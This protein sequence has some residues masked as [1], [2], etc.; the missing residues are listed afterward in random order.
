MRP[1]RIIIVPFEMTSPGLTT[2][3]PPTKACTPSGTGRKPGGNGSAAD[4]LRHKR[5]IWQNAKSLLI[6]RHNIQ[7]RPTNT[8]RHGLKM[9]YYYAP[10]RESR[11]WLAVAVRT[12]GDRN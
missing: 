10:E 4:A 6:A 2:T 8:S 9:C 7:N 12:K 1:S 3:L 5:A 11:P